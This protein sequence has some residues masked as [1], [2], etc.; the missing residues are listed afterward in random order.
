LIKKG[1]KK[2]RKNYRPT[3]EPAKP[4][5]RARNPYVRVHLDKRTLCGVY[6]NLQQASLVQRRVE[7]CQET[8]MRDVGPSVSDITTSLGEDALM[9]VAIEER[10]FGLAFP[11]V[12]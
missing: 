8:L 5:E 7:Q 11:P 10:V 12:T 6:V 3:H 4:L 1:G 9:I 2:G